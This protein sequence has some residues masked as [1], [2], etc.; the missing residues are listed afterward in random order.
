MEAQLKQRIVGAI[1]IVCVLAIFLP[2]LLHKPK[3]I[4]TQKMSMNIPKPEPISQMSLQL[5]K[6][7]SPQPAIEA[8]Q[9]TAVPSSLAHTEEGEDITNVPHQ[10]MAPPVQDQQVAHN[11][12]KIQPKPAQKHIAHSAHHKPVAHHVHNHKKINN[13]ILQAAVE[14]PEAWVVQLAS[15]ADKNNAH[16]LVNRLR[17]SGFEAY[18]R[19]SHLHGRSINRVFVGPEIKKHDMQQINSRLNRKFH[20]HGVVKRYH[21]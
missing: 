16:Q 9:S 19:T 8:P 14:T 4:V 11:V 17:K 20:L 12:P 7:D 2:V 21:V 13:K 5:A 3:P 1:V 6:Q 15:F 10:V 18:L